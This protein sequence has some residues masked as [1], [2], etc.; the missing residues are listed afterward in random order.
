MDDWII[1]AVGLLMWAQGFVFAGI[2]YGKT[3][4]WDGVR[5]IYRFG[6]P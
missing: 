5:S 6:R 1:A 2:L 3:P 4:F